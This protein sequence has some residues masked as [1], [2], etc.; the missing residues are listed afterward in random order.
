MKLVLVVACAS[1]L[2]AGCGYS[3]NNYGPAY[4]QP[5]AASLDLNY[6]S[7]TDCRLAQKTGQHCRPLRGEGQAR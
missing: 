2:L 1:A 7:L 5:G 3:Y 6:I 4:V